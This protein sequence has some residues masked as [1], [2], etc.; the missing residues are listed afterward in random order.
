[1]TGGEEK[2]VDERSNLGP[3]L[4]QQQNPELQEAR[5][6]AEEARAREAVERQR[7]QEALERERLNERGRGR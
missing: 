6:V 5:Q 7:A 4:S 2:P 1:L 3:H